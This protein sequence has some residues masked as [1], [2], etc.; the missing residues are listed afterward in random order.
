[1]SVIVNWL[2][3]AYLILS[4]TKIVA[5]LKSRNTKKKQ[6]IFFR[7]LRRSAIRARNT[8]IESGRF[9]KELFIFV[10]LRRSAISAQ[11]AD[12]F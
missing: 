6:P 9:E 11:S 8:T 1:M 10:F 7:D 12:I 3:Q 5:R 2:F 4:A